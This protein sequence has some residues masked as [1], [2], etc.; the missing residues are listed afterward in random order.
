MKTALSGPL[1]RRNGLRLSMV[2]VVAYLMVAAPPPA[3]ACTNFLVTR[4]ASVDGSTMISYAADSHVRYGQL[5]LRRGGEWP[6]GSTVQLRY[7]GSM[8]PLGEIPQAPKT[9]TVIGF[10]NENQVAI[11]ESTFGGRPELQDK[12]G[13]VDYGSLM[14]LAMD[15]ARSAREAIK[16]MAELVEEYGYYSTG[17]SFSIGDPDEVWIMEMMGKGTDLVFDEEKQK[18]VNRNKG[19]VWVAIRIPDGFISAHANHSRI[20]TFP[21]ENRRNSISSRNLDRIFDPAVEVVYAHDVIDFAREIGYFSGPDGEFSFSDAYAPMDFGAARFCEVRVWSFFRGLCSDMD[22]YTDFVRGENLAKRMPLYVKPDRKVSVADLMAAKRDHLS[23]TEFD[24]RHDPGAGPFELP[25]RW[26]PLT[27]EYEGRTYINERATATQQTGFSYIAQM[28]NWLPAPIGGI[29][30][31]GVDDAA[32]T[33]YN[34]MYCGITRVPETYAEGNGDLLT[35][36]D[37]AAFW[38]FNKVANFAYLRYTMMIEDV[39]E[40]QQELEEKY[41][42]YVPAIDQAAKLLHDQDPALAREFLTDFS[43]FAANGTVKRW[44]ELFRYLLVKYLDGNV[45]KESDGQ[46]TRNP[47]G[48][49]VQPHFPGYPESWKRRVVEETGDH[50]LQRD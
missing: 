23:G 31:F 6:E 27:W 15:R 49:P 29:L 26:R 50:L 1:T 37:S 7:R 8:K 33:V 43:A 34:P 20:T 22:Q 25:Y 35:Y 16:I 3:G 10:M 19:A 18:E 40:V 4:G 28:R 32:S 2:L 13:L 44:Q 38:V 24:M 9:Y 45:K 48:F 36:S 12:T 42:A 11:G 39:R 5:Y 14:H 46:F 21:L 47:Y 30:W 17:E 41:L